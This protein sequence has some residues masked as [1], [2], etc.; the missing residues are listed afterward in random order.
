SQRVLQKFEN[1]RPASHLPTQALLERPFGSEM[2][3]RFLAPCPRGSV[4]HRVDIAPHRPGPAKPP[5][6]LGA[7]LARLPAVG[8]RPASPPECLAG[9]SMPAFGAPRPFP[10]RPRRSKAFRIGRIPRRQATLAQVRATTLL[11][12]TSGQTALGNHP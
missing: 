1:H 7:A 5:P 8:P 3:P 6:S 2:T 10:V 12:R 4:P 9:S 11:S